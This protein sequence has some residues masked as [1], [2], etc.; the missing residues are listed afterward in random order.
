VRLSHYIDNIMP[1]S[2]KTNMQFSGNVGNSKV[3]ARAF[4]ALGL[5]FPRWFQEDEFEKPESSTQ[6]SI[7]LSHAGGTRYH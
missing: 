4:R 1:T 3:S 5:K 2:P 6:A 7:W